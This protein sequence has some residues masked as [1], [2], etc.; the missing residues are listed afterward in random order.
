MESLFPPILRSFLRYK[1][2]TLFMLSCGALIRQ[3]DSF[4]AL[5]DFVKRWI[6]PVALTV[7]GS[8]FCHS[9]KVDE[10]V[11]FSAPQL[12][13][14]LTCGFFM[15]YAQ[16]ILVEG[17][18]LNGNFKALL[19]AT[20]QSNLARHTNLVYFSCQSQGK[21]TI[22][23]FI[24]SHP[25]FRPWG[26]RIPPACP[27]CKSARPW[28]K[29]ITQSSSIIFVCTREGCKASCRFKKPDDVEVLNANVNGGRWMAR[30]LSV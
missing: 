17:Y 3:K 10:L 12:Q 7:S 5:A 1:E 21:L 11:A 23:E 4:Q 24:F 19:A 16:R 25:I 29:P 13:V 15:D 27:R 9:M 6:N 28:S 14:S 8:N 30:K 2:L 20:A 18:T 22:I 26:F